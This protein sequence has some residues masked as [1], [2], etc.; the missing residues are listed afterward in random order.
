MFATSIH[1]SNDHVPSPS[2]YVDDIIEANDYVPSP[3]G[4][5]DDI[6]EPRS[7]RKRIIQDLRTLASKTSSRPAKKHANIPLWGRG[8]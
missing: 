8:T 1:H 2:G 5:V 6:I 7:T 3:S 4:Y